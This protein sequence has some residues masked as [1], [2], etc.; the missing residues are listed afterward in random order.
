VSQTKHQQ[1]R[2][3]HRTT[4]ETDSNGPSIANRKRPSTCLAESGQGNPT[5]SY[6]PAKEDAGGDEDDPKP[7]L[8]NSSAARISYDT[9]Q[10]VIQEEGIR[11]LTLVGYTFC[12]ITTIRRLE[13]FHISRLVSGS[14]LIA[15]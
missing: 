11:K 9:T 6:S 13:R 7:Y 4:I 15:S 1:K 14:L 5:G 2:N 10:E 12:T 8:V 3:K